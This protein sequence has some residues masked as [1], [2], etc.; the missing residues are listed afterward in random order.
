MQFVLQRRLRVSGVSRSRRM[1]S[2]RAKWRSAGVRL[3]RLWWQLAWLFVS[4]EG[5]AS[6]TA[7]KVVT[8]VL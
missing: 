2:A 1:D 3:D 6:E 8:L 5:L 7:G 4:H